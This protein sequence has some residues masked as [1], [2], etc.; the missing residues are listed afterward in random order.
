M[1][2]KLFVPASRPE[3]FEKALNSQA[4]ALS[5]DLEDAVLEQHKEQARQHLADFLQTLERGTQPK[6]II[7]RINDMSTSWFS[8]DL[9]ACMLESVDLINIPKIESAEQ[10]QD[11]FVAFDKAAGAIDKPPAI[12]VNIE[13]PLALINAASIA[14]ADRRIAGLQLGLGDLFEPQGIHRYEPANVHHVMM[15]LRLAAGSA[16][17]YAY[18]TAYTDIRNAE[19]YRQEAQLARSLGFL[20]KTCIHPSQVAIANEVFTPTQEEIE[21][22]RKIVESAGN[23]AHGAYVLDGQMIDVPFIN[24]A[25]MIL[26]QTAET[27]TPQGDSSD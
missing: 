14:A 22:A 21:W 12:L 8:D 25:K 23:T 11:F 20:G 26:R 16:G 24:K 3:L 19:G 4:D 18:D 5:F 7:V 10:M 2:S 9:Q 27:S 17:V 1:K 13:T 15:Q 6:T